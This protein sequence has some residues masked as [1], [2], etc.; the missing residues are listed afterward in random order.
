MLNGLIGTYAKTAQESMSNKSV[1]ALFEKDGFRDYLDAYP[2]GGLADGFVWKPG[3]GATF[4][5]PYSKIEIKAPFTDYIPV[6]EGPVLD[7]NKTHKIGFVFHG[8]T[9]PG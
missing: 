9:I 5:G 4:T 8:F 6:K 3:M 2:I 7:P 1:K